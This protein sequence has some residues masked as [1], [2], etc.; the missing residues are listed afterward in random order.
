MS[1]GGGGGSV[2]GGARQDHSMTSTGTVWASEAGKLAGYYCLK[3]MKIYLTPKIK[4]S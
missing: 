2:G 4:Y 1:G 3:Y